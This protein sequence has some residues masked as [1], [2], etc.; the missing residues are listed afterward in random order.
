[1]CH[2]HMETATQTTLAGMLQMHC[3]RRPGGAHLSFLCRKEE[4][5]SHRAVGA[6]QR[7]AFPQQPRAALRRRSHAVR[8]GADLFSRVCLRL[9]TKHS[10]CL[11]CCSAQGQQ[12][13]RTCTLLPIQI[14]KQVC[15]TSA[16]E[17][18]R[19]PA[20]PAMQTCRSL[21]PLGAAPRARV[22]RPAMCSAAGT[23]AHGCAS[24][25]HQTALPGVN[26]LVSSGKGTSATLRAFAVR[27]QSSRVGKPALHLRTWWT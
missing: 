6:L 12:V 18:P 25:P 14:W 16:L 20:C 4:G 5:P 1:M 22:R 19:A 11:V 9:A 27:L 23:P 17:H 2:D 24:P 13:Y 8:F 7:A 21:P 3:L 26:V 15:W 10:M